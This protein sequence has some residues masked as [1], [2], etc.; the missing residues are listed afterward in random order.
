MAKDPKDSRIMEYKDTISQLNMTIRSQNNLIDSLHQTI[1]SNNEAK[2]VL[3]EKV[4]YLTKKLFGTSSEKPKN[5]EGQLSLFNEAAQEASQGNRRKKSLSKDMPAGQRVPMR[6][7]LK[8]CLRG[9]RSSPFPKDRDTVR[10]AERKWKPS[11]RS[12]SVGNSVLP[13]PGAK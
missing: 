7:S 3:N 4:D 2:A 13:L 8:V 6:I 1:A 11:G 12:L 5:V 9:M 10:N